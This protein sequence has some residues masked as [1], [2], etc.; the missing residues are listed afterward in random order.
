VRD[1]PLQNAF[2]HFLN[3]GLF[4]GGQSF[5]DWREA[6]AV[7]GRLYRAREGIETFDTCSLRFTLEGGMPLDL[8]L[9]HACAETL[10]P[11]VRIETEAGRIEWGIGWMRETRQGHETFR[12][13]I[14]L[15]HA[16]MFADAVAWT[17][18]PETF[19]C[20][21]DAAG[22]ALRA[23]EKAAELD[24]LPVPAR[25]LRVEA[26]GTRHW[27]GVGERLRVAFDADK[28]G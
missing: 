11:R 14:P 26:D 15:P 28:L 12:G 22:H 3:L 23:V 6:V 13:D 7:D 10:D 17:R 24:I 2:A 5:G 4:L 19:M 9:S 18:A 1:S 16:D 20:S 27:L 8:H 25:E 21:L